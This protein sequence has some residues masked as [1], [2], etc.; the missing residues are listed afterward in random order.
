MNKVLIAEYSK[1]AKKK[2]LTTKQMERFKELSKEMRK[3]AI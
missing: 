1:L 2:S 3:N